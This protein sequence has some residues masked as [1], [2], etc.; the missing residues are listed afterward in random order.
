MGMSPAPGAERRRRR[1][2]GAEP[3]NRDSLERAARRMNGVVRWLG[4]TGFRSWIS[5][6][7]MPRI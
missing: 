1:A 4:R 2:G 5:S 6:C 7:T 3:G